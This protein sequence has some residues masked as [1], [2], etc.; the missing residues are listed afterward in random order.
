[1]RAVAIE[2]TRSQEEVAGARCAGDPTSPARV[3]TVRPSDGG[4]P[5]PG[6]VSGR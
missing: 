2:G 1:M 3:Q 4:T 6:A 5:H